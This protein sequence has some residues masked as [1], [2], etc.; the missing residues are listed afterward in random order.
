M[1]SKGCWL[2]LAVGILSLWGCATH[3]APPM[4]SAP[5]AVLEFPASIRLLTLDNQAI[6]ARTRHQTLPVSPGRHTLQLM[7]VAMGIDGSRMHDGQ[8]TGPVGLEVQE[9]FR[10]RLVA[11]T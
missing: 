10:Y 5:Y 9:G 8:L 1:Y 2:G 4:P 11:K 7:Y 6:D 3:S